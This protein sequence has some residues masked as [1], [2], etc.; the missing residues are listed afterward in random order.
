VGDGTAE[1]ATL[2]QKLAALAVQAHHDSVERSRQGQQLSRT[3]LR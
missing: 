3:W 2:S 1:I